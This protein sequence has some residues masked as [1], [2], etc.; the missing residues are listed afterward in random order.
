ML[1]SPEFR[2]ALA[3]LPCSCVWDSWQNHRVEF[4]GL[5]VLAV[6][7]FPNFINCVEKC[8]REKGGSGV[9]PLS[10]FSPPPVSLAVV[11]GSTNA[12]QV[13]PFCPP[14]IVDSI[15]RNDMVYIISNSLITHLAHWVLL[16][17]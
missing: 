4:L 8:V 1:D 16:P 15:K 12:L 3:A 14:R 11:A 5:S 6:S 13:L 7:P 2:R 10:T 17:L 9:V